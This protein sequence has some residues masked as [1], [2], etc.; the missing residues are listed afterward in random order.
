MS[1]CCFRLCGDVE[2]ES[3]SRV[4][5]DGVK[6]VD[7]V[8]ARQVVDETLKR[9]ENMEV[10]EERFHERNNRY[11]ESK[12]S[13]NKWLI[14]DTRRLFNGSTAAST[15][16]SAA[17]TKHV[18]PRCAENQGCKR[19]VVECLENGEPGHSFSTDKEI[20]LMF[21]L[22]YGKKKGENLIELLKLKSMTL[23][24]YT[25]NSMPRVKLVH[26]SS[27][28][29]RPLLGFR[30]KMG[31]SGAE[32]GVGFRDE[33]GTDMD[34]QFVNWTLRLASAHD[35]KAHTTFIKSVEV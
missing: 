25:K 28:T 12:Q 31:Q 26:V 17:T 1:K 27:C 24:V 10:G 29:I 14:G 11:D 5:D 23:P 9:S 8:G 34:K 32:M 15:F 6:S 16:S 21:R 18:G 2:D 33:M 7:E 30:A 20:R 3:T 22:A 4:V 13:Y 35:K 19:Q